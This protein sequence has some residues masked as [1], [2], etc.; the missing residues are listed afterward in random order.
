MRTTLGGDFGF[1]DLRR[2][3]ESGL[4][5]AH[6]GVRYRQSPRHLHRPY[7]DGKHARNSA[8]GEELRVPLLK[9]RGVRVRRPERRDLH[10]LVV[11]HLL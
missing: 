4:I 8:D 10:Q 11:M 2:L 7:G 5:T 1:D 3:R 6:T 9:A